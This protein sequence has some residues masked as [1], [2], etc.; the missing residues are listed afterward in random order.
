MVFKRIVPEEQTSFVDVR[1]IDEAIE[2]NLK[3]DKPISKEEMIALAKADLEKYKI[4]ISSDD[5]DIQNNKAFRK[6]DTIFVAEGGKIINESWFVEKYMIGQERIESK[7][8]CYTMGLERK[9]TKEELEWDYLYT[10]LDTRYPN[11]DA[12]RNITRSDKKGLLIRIKETLGFDLYDFSNE[13]QARMKLLHLLYCF[14]R[15]FGVEFSSYFNNPTLE[16]I[17]DIIVN[18]ETKNGHLLEY[19]RRQIVRELDER[20]IL[21]VNNLCCKMIE[22]WENQL[23]ELMFKLD[24]IMTRNTRAELTSECNLALEL[25]E[26]VEHI[27]EHG[28]YKHGLLET[29]YLKLWQHENLGREN[30]ILDVTQRTQEFLSNLPDNLTKYQKLAGKAVYKKDL[31]KYISDNRKILAQLV[32]ESDTITSNQYKKFDIASEKVEFYLEM[33]NDNTSV[34]KFVDIPELLVIAAL[35]EIINLDKKEILPNKFYRYSTSEQRTL[36]SELSYGSSAFRKNQLVW[37]AR[38]NTRYNAYNGRKEEALLVYRTQSVLDKI[39]VALF[40]INSITDML[41]FHNFFLQL[42]EEVL[43]S[44]DLLNKNVKRFEKSVG[45]RKKGYV[46]RNLTSIEARR[47]FTITINSGIVDQLAKRVAKRIME[48]EQ[49]H[50]PIAFPYPFELTGNYSNDSDEYKVEF[51]VNPL[52]KTIEITAFEHDISSDKVQILKENGITIL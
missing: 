44:E 23:R 40:K 33:L 17:D 42:A 28:K 11:S 1:T 29:V 51:I 37:V 26:P 38:V 34:N 36:N 46:V 13:Q 10:E 3:H 39:I 43:V 48:A 9:L 5:Y 47:F 19:L 25:F 18:I 45:R 2:Y 35:Q 49:K 24:T 32:F 20:F 8:G 50:H 52:T 15:E 21:K 27:T 7:Y 31:Q 12:K 41:V 22:D 16:N 14:E 4:D 6:L 30:D